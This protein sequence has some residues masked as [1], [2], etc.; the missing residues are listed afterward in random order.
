[1]E[2]A[3]VTQSWSLLGYLILFL[4]HGPS[5]NSIIREI[6]IKLVQ[7][8]KCHSQLDQFK[9]IALP[10]CFSHLVVFHLNWVLTTKIWLFRHRG[11][12]GCLWGYKCVSKEA[13]RCWCSPVIW[14]LFWEPGTC[15]P[16][17]SYA[18]KFLQGFAYCPRETSMS[19]VGRLSTVQNVLLKLQISMLRG[20]VFP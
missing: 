11:K 15:S 20:C 16:D 10:F 7:T 19:S 8:G 2:E 6:A 5:T 17:V 14:I 18:N 13:S 4:A 1:M 9:W 3:D 12:S